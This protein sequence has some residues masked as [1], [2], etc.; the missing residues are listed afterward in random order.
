MTIHPA[1][2]ASLMARCRIAHATD[3]WTPVSSGPSLIS[4]CAALESVRQVAERLEA[5]GGRPRGS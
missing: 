5:E 1:R 2:P 3:S 4:A